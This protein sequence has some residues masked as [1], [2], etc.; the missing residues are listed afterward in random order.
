MVAAPRSASSDQTRVVALLNPAHR[1]AQVSGSIAPDEHAI[2]RVGIGGNHTV[3]LSITSLG[4]GERPLT[5]VVRRPNGSIVARSVGFR[6]GETLSIAA[7]PHTAYSLDLSMPGHDAGTYRLRFQDQ[8]VRPIH[9]V[10]PISSSASLPVSSGL[11][12]GTVAPF[13]SRLIRGVSSALAAVEFR[14]IPTANGTLTFQNLTATGTLTLVILPSDP[15]QAT[16]TLTIAPG[17]S[18]VLG[19]TAGT[20]YR[21]RLT[22]SATPLVPYLL[23]SSLVPAPAGVSTVQIV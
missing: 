15:L 8:S 1:S 20:S 7:N 4:P 21:V 23:S 2:V 16:Q 18:T 17:A 22:V 10:S 14:L 9:S 6:A 12:T 11:P 5:V 3:R 19:V 13:Q